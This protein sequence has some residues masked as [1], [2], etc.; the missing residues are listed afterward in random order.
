M[1]LPV[2]HFKRAIKAGRS[3][4]G[5]W[6]SLASN[7]TVEIL[8]GSGFDWLLLDMRAFAQRAADGPQPAAGGD[9]GTAPPDRAARPGTTR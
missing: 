5:L 8:A 3:Q 7:I 1:D 2:N 9:G 4:I 6:S